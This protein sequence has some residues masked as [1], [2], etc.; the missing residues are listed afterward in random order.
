MI[1]TEIPTHKKIAKA[2][3]EHEPEKEFNPDRGARHCQ[4]KLGRKSWPEKDK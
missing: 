4:A 3:D 1:A 2:D